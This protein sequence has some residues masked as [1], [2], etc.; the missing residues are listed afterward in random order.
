LK[1]GRGWLA[2]TELLQIGVLGPLIVR[3]GGRDLKLPRKAQ[4]LLA[5]LAMQR[6]QPVSR[7]RL[8]YLLWPDHSEAQARHGVR[9]A[10][11]D[12]RRTVGEGIDRLLTAD[13]QRVCLESSGI[14]LDAAGFED[15]AGS[16]SLRVLSEAART[17]RGEFLADLRITAEPFE[18]WVTEQRERVL[19][20]ASHLFRKLAD[21]AAEARDF[22][23]A[24]ATAR[25]LVELDRLS[26]ASHRALIE[27]YARAG[28]RSMALKQYETC[29]DLL[30]R[31]FGVE[32]EPETE[33]LAAALK[34]R[35]APEASSSRKADRADEKAESRGAVGA[36]AVTARETVSGPLEDAL[37]GSWFKAER[38]SVGVTPL[39][40]L[41]GGAVSQDTVD[42][43]TEDLISDLAGLGRG[44]TVSRLRYN[45]LD[46][47]DGIKA[48]L[49]DVRYLLTGNVQFA[50]GTIRLS[51]ALME[52]LSGEYLWTGRYESRRS[53]LAPTQTKLTGQISR[54]LHLHVI[55]EASRS[56]LAREAE[57]SA[58]EL[59]SEGIFLLTRSTRRGPIPVREAQI[60]FLRALA[61]DRRNADALAGLGHCC[62]RLAS[63]PYWLPTSTMLPAAIDLGRESVRAALNLNPHHAYAYCID[64]MLSSVAGDLQHA[65]TVLERAIS[66]DPKLMLARP[67]AGFNAAF[68]GRATEA[69]PAAE[70]ALKQH[71]NHAAYG[72]WLFTAGAGELL[73]DR[74]E[75]AMQLFDSSLSV[76]PTA[77]T[78]RLWLA[79]AKL[80]SGDK[81]G[82]GSII[83][84]FR[85][86]YPAYRLQE[87]TQ[88]FISRSR[89]PTYRRQ[90]AAVFQ[91]L[92]RLGIPD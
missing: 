57:Q 56:L 27:I 30:Q 44:F 40:N 53:E 58:E 36:R 15:A 42:G 48:S 16:D 69:A 31:E 81:S 21:R 3:Y 74:R 35:T 9:N 80:R 71:R 90:V 68:L 2:R 83:T 24:I 28:Q 4:A 5:Y 20:A 6:G 34:L 26:E 77:G 13:G 75:P 19:N 7:G 60:H 73:L 45:P 62:F 29:L 59:V 88:Q 66:I 91:E 72:A 65:Q 18:Q 1:K 76:D 85:E 86:R 55:H 84:D 54:E 49:S 41:S 87:F 47:G 17:H 46:S 8:A 50:K 10:L 39:R 79:A 61:R 63:H 25:R 52:A 22:P 32:P 92:R 51:M 12:I 38:L 78:P 70:V 89:H 33:A 82:A 23:L 67:F 64:G 14:E 37:S 11:F 43:L